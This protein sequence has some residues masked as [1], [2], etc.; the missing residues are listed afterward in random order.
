MTGRGVDQILP[1][2]GDPTLREAVVTAARTCVSLAEEVTARSPGAST[3]RGRGSDA[4][5]S[6]LENHSQRF[7]TRVDRESDYTVVVRA[8]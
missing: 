1:H 8:M 6:T 7:G 2:G 5:R 4:L 3:S